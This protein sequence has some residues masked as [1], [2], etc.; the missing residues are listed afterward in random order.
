MLFLRSP[1][2]RISMIMC[3]LTSVRMLPR[4][5]TPREVTELSE[6]APLPPQCRKLRQHTFPF[7]S[8]LRS[9]ILG[10]VI[11]NVK[12]GSSPTL[13]SALC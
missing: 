12:D 11:W 3:C 7:I 8:V 13:A 5:L 6:W 10:F 2:G 9:V 1:V 4:L